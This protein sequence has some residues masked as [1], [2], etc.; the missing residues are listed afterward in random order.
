ME[1]CC[2]AC[3]T[4]LV[5]EGPQG[6][7]WENRLKLLLIITLVYA[8]LQ[9]TLAK[10]TASLVQNSPRPTPNMASPNKK[11]VPRCGDTAL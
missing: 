1:M 8:F 4:D 11:A 3:K 7:S 9:Y 6:W 10:D 2:R 5:M